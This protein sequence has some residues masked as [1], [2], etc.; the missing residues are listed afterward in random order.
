MISKVLRALPPFKGKQRLSGFLLS[1]YLKQT[2]DIKIDG[3]FDC[4]YLLPNLT[5]TVAFELFINGIYEEDTVTFIVD[6][7]KHHKILLDVG[8]NIGAITIPICKRRNDLKVICL[9][10]APMVFAYLKRNIEMNGL[11][12]VTLVNKAIADIDGKYVNFYSPHDKFGKGSMAP[13]FTSERVEIETT[14]LTA[15]TK[16]FPITDIGFIKMDIEGFEYFA[17]EGGRELLMNRD[18]P[19]ILFEFANWAE[20]S[21]PGIKAGAAQKLLMDF[22]YQLYVFKDGRIGTRLVEPRRE[23]AMI[24]ATRNPS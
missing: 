24:F 16:S 20:D 12:Q 8:A 5:E 2:R 13:V 11:N 18:A 23:S 3:H 17:F 1:N 6:K 10:A 14:T 9:E 19:D 21:A 22:G 7:I 4:T 15:L